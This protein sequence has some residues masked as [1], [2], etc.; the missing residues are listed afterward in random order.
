MG[1]VCCAEGP[2]TE[3]MEDAEGVV[4]YKVGDTA[5]AGLPALLS[6]SPQGKVKE[7]SPSEPLASAAP[8]D[9][10]P[11]SVEPTVADPHPVSKQ[12]GAED[13]AR[14]HPTDPEQERQSEE[15]KEDKPKPDLQGEW[16]MARYEGDW[17]AFM[18]DVGV[19]WAM[20]KAA[21]ASG[22]G[23]NKTVHAIKL[24][25]ER[26]SVET[27]TFAGA[28]T[29][30]F[31][32]NGCDQDA[33]DPLTKKPVKIV[34][35]WEELGGR[36]ALT[37]EGYVPAAKVGG[38]IKKLPVTRRWLDGSSMVVEQTSPSGFVVKSYFSR[39]TV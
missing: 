8:Q 29:R 5:A 19:S 2:A 24:S 12:T 27:R 14:E 1:N 16:K 22:Y 4:M 25:G 37:M 3:H 10:E 17:D 30:E 28:Y 15:L 35:F 38:E 34:P 11:A 39:M 32:P 33:E 20:R 26:I 36:M 18:K 31:E 6:S 23:V 13:D 9:V 7:A 21:G